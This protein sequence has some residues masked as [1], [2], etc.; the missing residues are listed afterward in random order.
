MLSTQKLQSENLS[1]NCQSKQIKV[2]MLPDGRTANPYQSL[3]AQALTE[4]GIEV[5]FPQGYRRVLPLW[6]ALISYQ[7]RI[8]VIHLHWI[9]PFLK[10]NN[11]FLKAI[12]GVKFL[13]D[14]I[15]VRLTGV[16]IVWT[17]H[18]RLSHDTAFPK[19][20]LW[21]RRRIA[22]LADS[23]ILHNHATLNEIATEYQ[24]ELNKAT[25]IAHGNY[26]QFYQS[27]IDSIQARQQL[28]LPLTGNI[29]LH[30]GLLRPYKGI[31][32]LLQVWQEN[33]CLFRDSTLIIAGKAS[34]EYRQKLDKLTSR[35]NNV[36]FIPQFIENERIHL[37]FSAATFVVLPYVALLNSGS[38][39][40]AMSYGKPIIAPRLGSIPEM[41]R[42][43]DAL[44][45]DSQDRA[46]LLEALKVSKC[47]DLETLSQQVFQACDR[48]DWSLIGVKTAYVHQKVVTK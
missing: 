31:E 14:I 43:A 19:L 35:S 7:D 48:L 11:W 17:V 27:A 30:L 47:I 37:F 32:N 20:E 29:Y 44:L 24:F 10:G 45:Y 13:I 40:L 23:I 21:V 46:G 16:K 5:I 42:E 36:I 22:S 8:D 18:N 34:E 12:Y 25:V 3:L 15:L 33:E 6:R 28:N 38:L 9:L 4:S 41:L 1:I 39:I 2:L 26:R